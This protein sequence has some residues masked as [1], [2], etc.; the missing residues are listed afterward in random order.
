MPE[1]Q[2]GHDL[3]VMESYLNGNGLTF[4]YSLQWG[5]DLAVMERAG[6]GCSGCKPKGLQWGHDL[7]VME[8]WSEYHGEF[9]TL[10]A[11]MGP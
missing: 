10:D 8:S 4:H 7:A 5:H 1:L 11:S 3:A 2:W 6:S 9:E